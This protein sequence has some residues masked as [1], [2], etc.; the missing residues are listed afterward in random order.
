MLWVLTN[1]KKISEFREEFYKAHETL[2]IIDLSKI[3]LKELANESE[4]IVNHHKDCAIFIGYL[5]AG[6][7]LELCDQTRMRKLFRKFPVAVITFFPES[8]PYSWKTDIEILYVEK[9][10]ENG[11]SNIIDDGSIVQHKPKNG[12]NKAPRKPSNK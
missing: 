9:P 10:I 12:H 8:L 2:K 6:W 5:E 7:M 1:L 4:S 11:K 3:S